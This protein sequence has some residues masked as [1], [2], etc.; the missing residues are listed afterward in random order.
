MRSIVVFIKQEIL[1]KVYLL[2]MFNVSNELIFI[3]SLNYFICNFQNLNNNY[4]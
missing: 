4:V 1:S 3:I 2:Q